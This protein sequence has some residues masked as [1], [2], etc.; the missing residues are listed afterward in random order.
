MSSITLT[1]AEKQKAK[2]LLADYFSQ[3]HTQNHLNNVTQEGQHQQRFFRKVLLED[4]RPD[5]KKFLEFLQDEIWAIHESLHL[6][7]LSNIVQ[8]NSVNEIREAFK[9]M[10]SNVAHNSNPD[11]VLNLG[12]R[13]YLGI[14]ILTEALGKVYPDRFAIKNK[15]SEW[16]AYFILS[17]SPD[18]IENQMTYADFINISAQIWDLIV[19]EYHQRE[20]NYDSDRRLWYVDSFYLWIYERPQTK[21][22]MKTLGYVI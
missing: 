9:T 8:N 5:D 14:S 21:Q 22:I 18:Y 11:E 4:G 15:R 1:S 2:K 3:H 10:L 17:V 6:G 16:G 7:L 19:E 13:P 12:R 20:F